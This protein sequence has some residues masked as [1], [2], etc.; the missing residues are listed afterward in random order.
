MA[1]NR[2]VK[3]MVVLVVTFGLP[4][5]S[6]ASENLKTSVSAEKIHIRNETDQP[7]TIALAPEVINRIHGPE[8]II[9]INAPQ[10]LALEVEYQGNDAFIILGKTAKLG[11]IYVITQTNDVFTIEIIP[12]KKVKARVINL[13][14]SKSH[15]R[16]N[17]VRF[18][19]LDRETA[20]VDLIRSA[21][22]DTIPDSFNVIPK[23]SEIKAIEHLKILQRRTITIDG[24]PLRLN[25]YLVTI[26][27]LSAISEMPVEE[28]TFLTPKLTHTPTAI[29]LGRSLSGFVNGKVV[30]RH[31]KHVR[32]F[33]VEQTQD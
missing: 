15:A 32:L 23:S 22:A 14:A 2:I 24:V 5:L 8:P 26:E 16:A 4:L 3:L 30:I 9:K 20:A 29:A 17:R 7:V 18:A 31:G 11:V 28:R 12:D 6:S 19:K 21:F 25:E 1:P 10:T 33:I 13:D 27:P